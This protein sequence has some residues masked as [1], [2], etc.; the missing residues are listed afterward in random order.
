VTRHHR[1][2]SGQA[3]TR[4][5]LGW[6]VLQRVALHG[7]IA[8]CVLL[9]GA[10][11]LLSGLA[12][13]QTEV[14]LWLS[15]TIGQPVTV[16]AVHADWSGWSPAVAVE[17]VR[18][19]DASTGIG[20]ERLSIAI[21]TWNSLRLGEVV[22]AR[23]AVEGLELILE[24]LPDGQWRVQG[25]ATDGDAASVA[26]GPVLM[27]ALARIRRLDLDARRVVLKTARLPQEVTLGPLTAHFSGGHSAQGGGQDELRL[28]AEIPGSG[29]G[30][31]HLLAGWSSAGPKAW[32]AE[33][34]DVELGYLRDWLPDLPVDLRG[35]AA[36]QLW[37]P[38]ATAG[39]VPLPQNFRLRLRELALA[40]PLFNDLQI[41]GELHLG[42]SGRPP[43]LG[44]GPDGEP[45]P[46]A[47][48]ARIERAT[49]PRGQWPEAEVALAIDGPLTTPVGLRFA[50]GFLRLDDLAPILLR[51][52]PHP[53]GS[54]A[55]RGDLSDLRLH[56][57][58]TPD[59]LLKGI[60]LRGD[61][62]GFGLRLPTLALS[63]QRS[64]GRLALQGG[65]GLL[66]FRA[67]GVT[68]TG[69]G[70]LKLVEIPAADAD[71]GFDFNAQGTRITLHRLTAAHPALALGLSGTLA[72][73][74]PGKAKNAADDTTPSGDFFSTLAATQ[75]DLELM[76]ERG[77]F[78]RLHELLPDLPALAPARTWLRERLLA[79]H[80]VQGRGLFRGSLGGWP[81]ADASGHSELQLDVQG[82]RLLFHPEW[83]VAE[84]I[85]ARLEL[86]GAALGITGHKARLLDVRLLEGTGALADVRAQAPRLQLD[87]RL[88]ATGPATRR[89]LNESP[90]REGPGRRLARVNVTGTL[91]YA[92][93]LDV[94]LHPGPLTGVTGEVR[95]AGNALDVG[96]GMGLTH[97]RG[98]LPFTR[99]DWGGG[100]PL[101]ARYAG[102]PVRV[103]AG[104]VPV[105]AGGGTRIGIEGSAN[106]DFIKARMAEH[107]DVVNAFLVD[108]DLWPLITGETPFTARI[109]IPPQE[110]ARAAERRGERPVETMLR[111]DS[112]LA[113]LAINL[114]APLGKL[115][116]TDSPLVVEMGL[117]DA[118]PLRVVQVRL[119]ETTTQVH[120]RR[121]RAEGPRLFAGAGVR[122]GE[123][124][125]FMPD[126]PVVAVRGTLPE[127]SLT[128]WKL[129]LE[130][131]EAR[132]GEDAGPDLDLDFRTGELAAFGQRFRDL[133]VSGRRD[134]G[135]W[136]LAL[137]SPDADGRINWPRGG[138]TATFEFRR[139]ALTP[140]PVAPQAE[141][142][143]PAALP[144]IA[145]AVDDFHYAGNALGRMRMSTHPLPDGSGLA[146]EQLQFESERFRA[147]ASGQWLA[148]G[149]SQRSVFR[150]EV[151][152][153]DLR[154]LL[155]SFGYATGAVEGGATRMVI[156][157]RWPG[158]P[159]AFR[160]EK[161]SGEMT[162]ELGKGRLMD[163]DP[164]AGRLFGLLSLQTLPRRLALDFGDLFLEG[165]AFDR[166]KGTFRLEA[167][168][169]HTEDLKMQGPAAEVLVTG[170][171]GLAS[172]DYDQRVRVKPALSG[173]LPVAGAIFG[174]V[175][176]GI[177][178]A[179]YLGQRIFRE[180][181]DAIDRLFARHYTIT[182]PWTDP[183]ITEVDN[184]RPRGRNAG[185]AGN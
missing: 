26:P 160:L 81:H 125:L 172:R 146:L 124:D 91:D 158:P 104:G 114:P 141:A 57:R 3:T 52:L 77:D 73:P 173:A 35:R 184:A 14:A 40:E 76:L 106:R 131:E 36:I 33:V 100:S 85:D 180:I 78:T 109:F 65:R 2:S 145:G 163:V 70:E 19:G 50:A 152:A 84:D 9:L 117:D 82:G 42:E 120:L 54:E 177:G 69:A 80:L 137:A 97:L 134:N 181:P 25:I 116:A 170:R 59:G 139:L 126:R 18:L 185:A 63:T 175:G 64:E 102:L 68:A 118:P 83:P 67:G 11:M 143:Q 155:A 41:A 101:E 56:W 61:F 60:W 17:G 95:F 88:A 98:A 31:L 47:L 164:A 99:D 43:L 107:A 23:I 66:S 90:L 129:L 6:R 79:G 24:E 150:I 140:D 10:R 93:T 142:T 48:R 133:H 179:V 89:L 38:K 37:A 96:G 53:D 15:E 148:R 167:G 45:P 169:A 165:F 74:A 159:D 72:L 32:Y 4:P 51:Q 55:L 168:N 147:N 28:E 44:L 105:A 39:A 7:L 174:P 151:N 132:Q 121:P 153:P 112:T 128:A 183:V 108:H 161:L 136:S 166:I 130:E 115:A 135:G 29:G 46:L 119:G 87:M 34:E 16:T 110:A 49:S 157:A 154:Q 1:K 144:A 94:P 156:D 27:A 92:L 58:P 75:A 12:G 5:A 13:S 123:G 176:I 62:A 182:G 20:I 111:I 138:G 149:L 71:L 162:L 22:P 30:R 127:L 113:G 122:L 103:T 8:F 21:D 86:R 171:T 178:A